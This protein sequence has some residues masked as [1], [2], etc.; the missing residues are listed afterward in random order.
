MSTVLTSSARPLSQINGTTL[1]THWQTLGLWAMAGKPVNV[2][3]PQALL[4]A[5]AGTGAAIQLHI[6]GWTDSLWNKESWPRL[7]DMVR[8]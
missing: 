6:G 5:A 1:T 3:L 2:T 8:A 4:T 7:P